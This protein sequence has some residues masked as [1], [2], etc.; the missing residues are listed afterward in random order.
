MT[1]Y[2]AIMAAAWGIGGVL[3]LWMGAKSAKGQLPRNAFAGIRTTTMM[4][5]DEAWVVGHK[6]AA[7]YFTGIGIVL[8]IAAIACLVVDDSIIGWISI[9]VVVVLLVGVLLATRKANVAVAQL[10]ES[11]A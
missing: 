1:V 11:S 9:P 3:L 7:G 6:A 2:S 10:P 8:V 4:A 5:S